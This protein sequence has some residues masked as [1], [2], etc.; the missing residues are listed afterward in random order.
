MET[1]GLFMDVRYGC[2]ARIK[3]SKKYEVPLDVADFTTNLEN[4]MKK[5]LL[6]SSL[7]MAEKFCQYWSRS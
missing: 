7:A 4:I 5:V 2:A 1:Q 3:R 6:Y